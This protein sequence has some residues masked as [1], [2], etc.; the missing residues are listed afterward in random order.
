MNTLKEEMIKRVE[1]L[2]EKLEEKEFHLEVKE[3]FKNK[4]VFSFEGNYV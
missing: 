1:E 2:N 3:A 4:C